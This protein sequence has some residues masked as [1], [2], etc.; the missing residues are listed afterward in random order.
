[1]TKGQLRTALLRQLK[2]QKEED[3]RRRSEAIARKVLRLAAVRRAS[4]V[5]CYVALPYEVQTWQM[6][7]G[8]LARGKRVVVPVVQPRSKRLALSEVRHPAADLARGAFGV[9]EP[10]PRA[11]R[12]VRVEEV[13]VVLVPGVAFDQRGNRLGHGYG[14]FDRF[15]E[16]LPKRVPTIGLAF[17]FQLIHHLPT[18]SHDHAVQTVL[19]A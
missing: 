5:C 4:V 7:K 9:L 18:T 13:D 15:L 3:R 6:M 12:P 19:S 16:R 10:T 17:R 11:R 14:Y 1:M 2:Q 8:L